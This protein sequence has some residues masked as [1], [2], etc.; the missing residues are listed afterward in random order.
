MPLPSL[1][2]TFFGRRSYRRVLD[3]DD[4][5]A[6]D[7][8]QFSSHAEVQQIGTAPSSG[9]WRLRLRSKLRIGFRRHR[10]SSNPRRNDVEIVGTSAAAAISAPKTAAVVENFLSGPEISEE[11]MQNRQARDLLRKFAA[12]GRVPGYVY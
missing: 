9:T 11:E 6:L 5:L 4:P 7:S 2:S 8:P 10:S 12:S 1:T 3:Q